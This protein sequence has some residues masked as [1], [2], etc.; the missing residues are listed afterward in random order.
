MALQCYT[1]EYYSWLA[2]AVCML[3]VYPLGVPASYAVLLYRHRDQLDPHELVMPEETASDSGGSSTDQPQVLEPVRRR[4]ENDAAVLQR[5]EDVHIQWLASLF[6]AYEP[7]CYYFEVVECLRR[8]MLSAMLVMFW[9]GTV[10]QL[11]VGCLISFSFMQL[12]NHASPF[13]SD[14]DDHLQNVSQNVTFLTLFGGLLLYI[15]ASGDDAFAQGALGGIMVA[16]QLV[17]MLSGV[18]LGALENFQTQRGWEA[19]AE[20]MEGDL[21]GGD[22]ME[23]EMSEEQAARRD[24]SVGQ[25]DES[26]Q[27]SAKTDEVSAGAADE[28]QGGW[29][30]GIPVDDGAMDGDIPTDDAEAAVGNDP[31]AEGRNKPQD[32]EADGASDSEIGLIDISNPAASTPNVTPPPGASRRLG[33][34]PRVHPM[35]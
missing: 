29:D 20:S 6:E 32:R 10:A 12:Y 5:E 1:P 21:D 25:R 15:D 2:F 28:A 23:V 4:L 16:T 18:A 26:F 14:Y 9:D 24:S 17:A 3:F 27:S 8:L 22:E 33:S 35:G 7:S 31:A 34:T 30:E 13:L 19:L 11:V